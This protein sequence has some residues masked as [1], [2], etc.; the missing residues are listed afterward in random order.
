VNAKKTTS[1]LLAALFVLATILAG[2]SKGD[3]GKNNEASPSASSASSPSASQPAS[4]EAAPSVWEV[5]S[6]PLEFS[7]Y[8]HYSWSDAPEW[9]STP[10]GRYAK[11]KLQVNVVPIKASGNHEQKLN[12]MI[13]DGKLPD[14]IWGDRGANVERLREAGMLVPLD[15]YIA[16]YPNLRKWLNDETINMLRSPDGKLYTFPNWYNDEPYGNAGYLVNKKIHDE[17][18]APSL[19]TTDDLYNYLKMVKEKYGNEIIPFEPHLAKDLHGIGLL[20]TA[21]EENALYWYLGNQ[22]RAIPKGDQLTSVFVDPTFRES[23]KYVAKLYREGLMTQDAMTQTLDQITE[24]VTTGRVAVYAGSSPTTVGMTAQ[25]ELEKQ[26]HPGYFMTWPIHKPGLDRNKI[27]PGSYATLGWN[28]AIIT[29]SAK[30]PEKIFAFLDWMTGSEGHA[31]L[32]YGPEGEM[33]QGFDADGYPNF[34]AAL[35]VQKAAALEA[36]NESI[37]W[38]GNAKLNDRGKVKAQN[39]LPPEKRSWIAKIQAEVSWPTQADHTEF[40]NLNPNPDTEEGIIRQTIDDLFNEVVAK[41]LMAKSDAEVDQIL[42]KAEKD[43]QSA[44]YDKLLQWRTV[45]WHKNQEI[46]KGN[47]Q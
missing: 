30:D 24:K 31:I 16:K 29:T 21:F 23:Q 34:S 46:M 12:T 33:W 43:A 11:E 18:G 15:D 47:F 22:M 7:M 26:G 4:E 35:D 38:V 8:H 10:F 44:G 14:V 45:E 9:D 42:D 20:Y 19:E 41:T 40:V 3:N 36:E 1:A 39:Q 6:E 28:A 2:C 27:F 32:H 5:G 25:I 37:W 13:A 17:L